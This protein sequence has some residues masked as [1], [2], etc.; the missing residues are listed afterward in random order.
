M[1]T[2]PP[3]PKHTVLLFWSG[4]TS[5]RIAEILMK[6]L[7]TVLPGVS[8]W[9]S[10]AIP[11]GAVW[12]EKL[13]EQISKGNSAILCVTASNTTSPWLH[14][15]AG[16]A[17]KAA[18]D[19]FVTPLLF[20]V[21]KGRLKLPLTS[22]QQGEITSVQ[23]MRNLLRQI[24]QRCAD[25]QS[26]DKLVGKS[27]D[28]A[29][30]DLKAKLENVEDDFPPFHP[31]EDGEQAA[32]WVGCHGTKYDVPHKEVFWNSLLTAATQRFWLVGHSNKSWIDR[33]AS[34]SRSLGDAIV[35]ICS[36]GGEVHV[37]SAKK[38]IKR[39]KDFLQHHVFRER[40]GE[41]AKSK[42][43]RLKALTQ[44]LTYSVSPRINYSAVVSDDRAL[45]IPLLN[46][47]QFRD[48][49]MVIELTK[50]LQPKQ[51]DNYMGDI[52]RLVEVAD[53]YF[54]KKWANELS[55]FTK[56]IRK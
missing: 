45:I 6:W 22:F 56:R 55:A 17:W 44:H 7:P 10:H 34:Q 5:E 8:P 27:F 30:D 38:A 9:M 26:D 42:Q 12:F 36:S 4:A 20:R 1:R 43:R 24:N 47:D 15:E 2:P 52:E 16:A 29:L 11:K 31:F 25:K 54:P 35:R 3:T 21:E 50:G 19:A 51:F 13:R 32:K 33:N 39:T 28:D 48:E 40:D 46:T 37:V 41:T 23:D 53:N 18:H 49:S 14:F